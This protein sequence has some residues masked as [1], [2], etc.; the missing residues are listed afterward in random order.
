MSRIV[1][2]EV[3]RHAHRLI[4]K[5]ASGEVNDLMAAACQLLDLAPVEGAVRAS[6]LTALTSAATVYEQRLLPIDARLIEVELTLSGCRADLVWEHRDGAVAIDE[7]KWSR[8]PRTLT[9]QI[10]AL[11]A[12]GHARW[13]GSFV[14]VRRSPLMR[15]SN[16]ALFAGESDPGLVELP[17]WLEVR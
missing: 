4:A 5:L 9:K 1:A 13:P 2:A 10:R 7:L 8:A 3:G 11:V 15:P 17:K 16:T 14:G 6:V 12:S